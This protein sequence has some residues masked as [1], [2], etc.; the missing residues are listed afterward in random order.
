MKTYSVGEELFH[1]DGQMDT[2][3]DTHTHM[4]IHTYIYTDRQTYRHDIVNSSFLQ[5]CEKH[6]KNGNIL[7]EGETSNSEPSVHKGALTPKPQNPI[8]CLRL[9]RN[10][11]IFPF[12][13]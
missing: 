10:M 11:I 2:H 6:L 5:F 1:A 9:G 8:K 12:A 4:Y 3:T 13:K 7:S